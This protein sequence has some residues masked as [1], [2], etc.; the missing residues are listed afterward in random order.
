MK[1]YPHISE[2]PFSDKEILKQLHNSAV[3]YSQLVNC[4][5]LF[6]Y[7]QN[8]NKDTPWQYFETEFKAENFQHLTGCKSKVLENGRPALSKADFYENALKQTLERKDFT[9]N[10]NRKT[11][12]AKL[13]SLPKLLQYEFAKL[14]EVG[15]KNVPTQHNVF[16]FAV[17]TRME[18]LCYSHPKNND[19][20]T[21]PRSVLN[22]PIIDY[23]FNPLKIMLIFKKDANASCYEDIY[24]SI[25][26]LEDLSEKLKGFINEIKDCVNINYK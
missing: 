6:I 1:I 14:Y 9:F 23:V 19:I 26:K 11:A 12:S 8:K 2:N 13:R 10:V 24:F 5:L 25:C 21:V 4:N 16:D 15:D 18:I 17:G 20:F 3:K 7:A 22:R